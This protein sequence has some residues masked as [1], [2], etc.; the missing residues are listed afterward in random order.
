MLHLRHLK[1][2][3]SAS[4]PKS[5]NSSDKGGQKLQTLDTISPESCSEQVFDTAC[6]LK[7]LGIRGP[8]ASLIDGKIGS[9]GILR[10]MDHLE[11]LKLLNDV[12]PRP[13]SEG[14]LRYLP[15]PHEFPPKLKSLTLSDTSLDW[16][17]MSILGS[18]EKLIVLKLKYN[19]FMGKTWNTADGGFRHLE[20]LHIGPTNLVVW[21]ASGHHFPKLRRLELYNCEELIQVPIGL[22]DIQSLQFLELNCS[23]FAAASAK[24]I[25]NIKKQQEQTTQ[26]SIFKLS[27]FPPLDE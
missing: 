10:K 27:V 24:E 18:L 23:N 2:N 5:D 11:N 26:V 22:A 16:S 19:A 6:N 1:T 25:H 20:V 9:F 12:F 15:Q 8:L 14:Q 7:K 21:N 13:T 4:L 3:A 17:H